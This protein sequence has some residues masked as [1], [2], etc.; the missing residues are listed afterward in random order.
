MCDANQGGAQ[1]PMGGPSSTM[2]PDLGN[3]SFPSSAPDLMQRMMKKPKNPAWNA[4]N[5]LKRGMQGATRGYSA[6]P[7]NNLPTGF[8]YRPQML[9]SQDFGQG[10]LS[11]GMLDDYFRNQTSGQSITY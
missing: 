8:E 6:R 9:S 3:P 11:K 2:A 4:Q 7:Q 5:M 1:S 10:P